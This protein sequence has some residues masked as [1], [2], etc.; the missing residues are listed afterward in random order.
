MTEMILT[1]QQNK[2]LQEVTNKMMGLQ[3]TWSNNIGRNWFHFSCPC[4]DV[5][6]KEGMGFWDVVNEMI[7]IYNIPQTDEKIVI[8]NGASHLFRAVEGVQNGCEGVIPLFYDFDRVATRSMT[9]NASEQASVYQDRMDIAEDW[10]KILLEASNGINASGDNK[11]FLCNNCGTAS[12]YK[13]HL[14][15]RCRQCEALVQPYGYLLIHDEEFS[16]TLRYL[17]ED[18]IQHLLTNQKF[19]QLSSRLLGS[20]SDT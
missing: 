11:H 4:I 15:M 13:T 5:G 2:I 14:Q 7:Y 6:F 18:N 1:N 20:I 8:I 17:F 12:R 10:K 19:L 3:S 16:L 9:K